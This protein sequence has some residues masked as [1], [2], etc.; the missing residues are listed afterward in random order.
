MFQTDQQFASA[1]F[2]FAITIEDR[3]QFF[4]SIGCCTDQHKNALFLLASS[5][6]RTLT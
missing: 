3:N 5:S 6:S 1:L 4:T 2:A